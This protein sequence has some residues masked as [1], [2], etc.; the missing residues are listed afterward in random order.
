MNKELEAF[1]EKLIKAILRGHLQLTTG[2]VEQIGSY[3][4]AM[5]LSEAIFRG[6]HIVTVGKFQYGNHAHLLF[7]DKTIKEIRKDYDPITGDK[8]ILPKVI[9]KLKMGQNDK[10]VG[11]KMKPSLLDEINFGDF[12]TSLMDCFLKAQRLVYD[13]K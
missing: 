11:M 12:N 1:L 6:K 2:T 5:V 4:H 7:L 10:I 13:A 8:K 9:I 3:H